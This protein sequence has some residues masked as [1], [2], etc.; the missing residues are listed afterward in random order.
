MYW[1]R[2]CREGQVEDCFERLYQ[3]SRDLHSP[4][5]VLD[6]FMLCFVGNMLQQPVANLYHFMW[7]RIVC[8][9]AHEIITYD[10]RGPSDGLKTVLGFQSRHRWYVSGTP[11]PHGLDS[12]RAALQVWLLSDIQHHCCLIFVMDLPMFH[13][14]FFGAVWIGFELVDWWHWY[15]CIGSFDDKNGIYLSK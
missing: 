14:G 11:F 12:L 2:E 15:C 1:C 5:S 3:R 10:M 7:W 4:N 8:D 13:L 6:V 9:E